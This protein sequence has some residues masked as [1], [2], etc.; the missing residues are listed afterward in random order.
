MLHAVI[1]SDRDAFHFIGEV[2]AYN[3][4]T[5][6][7]HVRQTAKED[8]AVQLWVEIDPGDVRTFER[9]ADKWLSGLARVETVIEVR[10]RDEDA[11]EG[12]PLGP[13]GVGAPSACR[14]PA[15]SSTACRLQP[16][17]FAPR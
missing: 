6:R 2:S 3:L 12:A 9:Y 17:P 15:A 5:L 1:Q 8:G 14:R 13:A 4:Q 16:A 11:Y 10:G 7:Q